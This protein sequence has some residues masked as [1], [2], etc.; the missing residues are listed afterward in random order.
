MSTWSWRRLEGHWWHR[1]PW[2]FADHQ[3]GGLPRKKGG[4][5]KSSKSPSTGDVEVLRDGVACPLLSS[6]GPADSAAPEVLGAGPS[7][8]PGS[9]SF[10]L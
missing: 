7:H 4:S 1:R 2:K 8:C 10:P 3:F 6:P 9:S 5:L